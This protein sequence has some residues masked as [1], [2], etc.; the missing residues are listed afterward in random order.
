MRPILY[1]FPE[2]LLFVSINCPNWK[3]S[4]MYRSDNGKMLEIGFVKF[5]QNNNGE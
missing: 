2:L 3:N 5:K 4:F 1:D